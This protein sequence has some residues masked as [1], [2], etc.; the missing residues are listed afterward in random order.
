ML[1][2]NINNYQPVLH[3]IPEEQKPELHHGGSLDILQNLPRFS[4]P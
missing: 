3:N 1:S 4:H 2:R